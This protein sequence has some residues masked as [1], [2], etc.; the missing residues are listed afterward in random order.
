[1]PDRDIFLKIEPISDYST[2]EPQEDPPAPIEYRRDCMRNKGHTDGLIPDSEVRARTLTALVYRE[3]EDPDYSIPVMDKLIE[4]DI[5]EPV[6]DRRVP[7]AV[8]YAEPGETLHIHVKNADSAPHSFHIH[9]LEYGIDADGA[10]PFGVENVDGDRS[11]EICP[12]GSWT[13][14]LRVTGDMIGAWPFHDHST[15]AGQSI[16]R[17]LFGGLVV[18]PEKGGPPKRPRFPDWFAEV[19]EDMLAKRRERPLRREERLE[20]RRSLQFIKEEWLPRR[21]SEEAARRES[22]RPGKRVKE[23]GRGR[24]P[25]WRRPGRPRRK[26]RPPRRP[27]EDV[28][29]IPLF[30]HH[31]STT[32]GKPLFDT[33]DL[34]EFIGVS[35]PIQ[36][37]EEGDFDYFC[38]IHASMEGV[39][40]VVPGGDAAVTVEI[41]DDVPGPE[42]MGFWP[43]EVT[44][45][46]GGTVTWEN[47]SSDHHTATAKE[48]AAM[49]SHCF[50]GRSF[51]G[52][53]PTIVVEAGETLRWYI[54]N[55]DL[56]HDWHNYHPHSQRWKFDH[57][58]VDVRSLGPAESFIIDTEAPPVLLL[59]EE[60]EAIQHEDDRPADAEEYALRGDFLFHC[61]VHHH[62]MQGMVGVVRVLQDVWLTPAMVEELEQTT[63]LP[64]SDGTNECPDVVLDRC[65]KH[66]IGSWEEVPGDPE[67]TMMHAVLLPQS[68]R[69]LY[70]GYTFQ[71]RSRIWDASTGNYAPPNNQYDDVAADPADSGT[72]DLWSAEHDFLDDPDGSVLAH[73]G[74]AGAEAF[75]FNPQSDLWS[76]VA[77][78]TDDRFYSSTITQPDGRLLTFW[79]GL[80]AGS[81]TIEIYD[82]AADSWSAPE[83]L[84]ATFGYR[85]Y[86]W[87]YVLPGGDL[88]VAGPQKETRRFD[89]AATPIVDDPAKT[90]VNAI[91]ADRV[92]SLTGSQ[93]GTSV[94]AILRPPNYA[95]IILNAGGNTAEAR[96]T[97]EWI[98]LSQPD[99]S[100]EQVEDMVHERME[101]TGVLLPDGRILVAGGMAGV[102]GPPNGGPAEIFDPE[103]PS[104]GWLQTPV[105]RHQRRYHSTLILLPDGSV[106]AGGDPRIGGITQHE[107]YFPGY[108]FKT[109][110]TMTGAP[111]QVSYG[112]TFTIDTPSPSTILEIVLIRPGAVTHGFN[113]AQRGVECVIE[114]TG[115]GTLDVTAPPGSDIAP[116]GW[117]LI[118]AVDAN[119]VPS[120]G[121]WL[122]LTTP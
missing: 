80:G 90:W 109:R 7:G 39:V 70:W 111:P 15:S 17:G 73:G 18:T 99:P 41:L 30:F 54:Y 92:S 43:K 81:P 64:L 117:Y 100:W 110:P 51:V 19:R 2:V 4:S 50:N 40:H 35:D 97:A 121:R 71:D 48:G 45:G 105:M 34:E 1:M 5:N 44:I 108:F 49:P 114:S 31:M 59:S 27:E 63:G 32:E 101:L 66:G 76:R 37:D 56:G 9:G 107:R 91:D 116:P 11:D 96:K 22:V 8:V 86:P 26:P 60:M 94:L 12:G 79:G 68:E 61:H 3:Y 14:T 113:M 52:N 25:R 83:A 103:S 47:K 55:L 62:M 57:D 21:Q 82:P 67:V 28:H 29:H 84:P 65:R 58:N 24:G 77:S 16:A 98:D 36:F 118:F 119:R 13:Y 72:W 93:K 69:V 6:F 42:E 78:G 102:P 122:R 120:V 115:A 38:Q 23:K 33:G 46:V 53:T 20:L 75:V 89:P 87:I 106:L 104:E 74:F 88:F 95:P 85:Y 112:E 10:W